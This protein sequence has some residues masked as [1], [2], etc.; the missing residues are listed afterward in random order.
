MSE[1]RLLQVQTNSGRFPLIDAKRTDQERIQCVTIAFWWWAAGYVISSSSII[2]GRTPW[3]HLSQ[4]WFPSLQLVLIVSMIWSVLISY[5]MPA[6]L[7]IGWKVYYHGSTSWWCADSGVDCVS[8]INTRWLCLN[9]L[10]SFLQLGWGVV[11]HICQC[12]EKRK[13]F[14]LL[15]RTVHPLLTWTMRCY[16][17]SAT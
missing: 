10:S 6:L 17:R 9:A 5:L 14:S 3:I 12:W 15:M 13:S 1:I 7:L 8:V 11:C 2:S 4:R 16:Y